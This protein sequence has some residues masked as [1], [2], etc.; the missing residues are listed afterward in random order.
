MVCARWTYLEEVRSK[1]DKLME[2]STYFIQRKEHS[3]TFII[4][5]RPTVLLLFWY[6][7]SSSVHRGGPSPDLQLP[8]SCLLG[9]LSAL[10]FLPSFLLAFCSLS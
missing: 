1:A 3:W 4:A 2:R 7:L 6:L 8:A 9:W 10:Q 5:L